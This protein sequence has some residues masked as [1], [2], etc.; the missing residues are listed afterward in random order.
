MFHLDFSKQS[1]TKLFGITP[2]PMSSDASKEEY[3]SSSAYVKSPSH[4]E[5]AE[6][7]GWVET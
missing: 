1:G 4:A 5:T 7:W 2:A 3:W 6:L